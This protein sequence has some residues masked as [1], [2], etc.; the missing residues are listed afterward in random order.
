MTTTAR[1][2]LQ[3]PITLYP[4][5]G[6]GL[7]VVA[8]DVALSYDAG[9]LRECRLTFELDASQYREVATRGLFH[10]APDNRGPGAGTFAPG[11]TVRIEARLDADLLSEIELLGSSPEA[12]AEKLR[13]SS[14]S[15][16]WSPLVE[17]ESWL[18]LHVTSPVP[19]E[20]DA[21]GELRSGY[22]TIFALSPPPPG[23]SAR[24]PAALHLP[25][26]AVAL[27][28]LQEREI[29]WEETT[30]PEVLRAAVASANGEW[31]LY[32]VCREEYGRCS[33]YSQAPWR[34][35]EAVRIAMAELLARINYGIAIGNFEMDFSDGEIRFK[36]SLDVAGGRLSR[37]M[38]EALLDANL[39]AMDA[40][41]PALEAV[42]DSRMTPAE[43]VASV[44]S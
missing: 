27:D 2:E 18:A 31:S 9:S 43:A 25:I 42:R 24:P 22:S 28:V 4:P 39:A 34:T 17:T 12:L 37:A 3:T 36:T 10:L 41:L 1:A 40:Y 38:F 5:E 20:I 33:I 35:P 23:S 7:E 19:Q 8:I 14:R 15:G 29:E 16:H 44:E 26:R 21:S 32:V 11:A 6:A 30:D 13:D